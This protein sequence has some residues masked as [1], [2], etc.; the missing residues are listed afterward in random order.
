MGLTVGVAG[1]S[2]TVMVISSVRSQPAA[3]TRSRY[4]MVLSGHTCCEPTPTTPAPSRYTA[5]A[6]STCHLSL[7]HSPL[8][9]VPRSALKLTEGVGLTVTLGLTVREGL[10]VPAG[11]TVGEGPTVTVGLMVGERPGS[12]TSIVTSAVPS[13]SSATAWSRY[14][15]LC[16]GHTPLEPTGAT[17]S[18]SR[19]TA[20]ASSTRHLSTVQLPGSK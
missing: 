16:S 18:P 14:V 11:L 7:V 3:T 4:V 20:S 8:S 19:W 13:Q 9:K 6:F 15:T 10:T 5:L 12:S 1:D 17:L 2:M